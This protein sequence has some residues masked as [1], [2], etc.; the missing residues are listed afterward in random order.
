MIDC[1]KR[2]NGELSIRTTDGFCDGKTSNVASSSGWLPGTL[3]V[4]ELG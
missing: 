1:L 4:V 2:V 3:H